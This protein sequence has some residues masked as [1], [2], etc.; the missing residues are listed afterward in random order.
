MAAALGQGVSE[1]AEMIRRLQEA[2]GVG[3]REELTDGAFAWRCLCLILT[4]EQRGIEALDPST[5]SKY[6]LTDDRTQ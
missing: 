6:V 4:W 5:V 3:T 2:Y 1:N